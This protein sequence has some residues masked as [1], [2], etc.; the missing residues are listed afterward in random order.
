MT[1]FSFGRNWLSYVE[2]MTDHDVTEAM[3]DIRRMLGPGR[4]EGKTVL[5]VG[6]GSGIHSLAFFRLGAASVRSFDADAQSVAATRDLWEKEG[7]P[8]AWT[9]E[10]GSILDDSWTGTL[11]R[12][13]IVYSWGVLHHTGAMWRAVDQTA[14][15]VASG[16]TLWIALYTKGGKYPNHLALKQRYNDAPVPVKRLYEMK[17][18]ARLVY[19]Q[20]RQ[21]KNPLRWNKRTSRGMNTYIDIVDWLGGLPYEVASVDEVL[22][23]LRKHSLVAERIDAKGEGS[24]SS[25]VFT[26][27]ESEELASTP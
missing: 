4:V 15:L 11:G 1:K 17:Q 21:G 19:V 5:D 23:R 3:D 10:K 25:Y 7:R 9:V 16:G 20:V 22:V 18:V 27:P 14:Q 12:F 8:G 24:C 6:S 13:D 2:Q 26:L